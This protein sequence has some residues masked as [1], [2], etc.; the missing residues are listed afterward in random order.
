[1]EEL[2]DAVFSLQPSSCQGVISRTAV[3]VSLSVKSGSYSSRWKFVGV[4]VSREFV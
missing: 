4:S 3:G 1:M 2:L